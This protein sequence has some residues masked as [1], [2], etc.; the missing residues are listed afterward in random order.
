MP[1]RG[2]KD[3][4]LVFVAVKGLC[5]GEMS[6]GTRSKRGG[7]RKD[8]KGVKEILLDEASVPCTVGTGPNALEWMTG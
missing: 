5:Y 1:L 7:E 8:A 6:H 4:H 3:A 2:H